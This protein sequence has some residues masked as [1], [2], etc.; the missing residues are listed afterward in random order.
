LRAGEKLE[1]ATHRHEDSGKQLLSGLY[2]QM[3]KI[4]D[5]SGQPVFIYL[6]DEQKVCNQRF[7]DFLG[8]LSPQDWSKTP[9]FLE[10]FVYDEASKNAFM[11]AYWSAIN[12][13][14][15]SSVEINWRRKDN[16]KLKSTMIILPMTYEGH[17]LSVHFII[18]A[19]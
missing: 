15:A 3:R 11:T 5:S 13:M 18:S 8:Y 17:I 6:D 12:N 16:K 14:N 7:A 19:Q 1:R 2:N 9:G 4:L 10:V